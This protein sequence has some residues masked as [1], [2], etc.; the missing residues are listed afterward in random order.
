M[1]HNFH[2]PSAIRRATSLSLHYSH[3]PQVI[4][5]AYP[6]PEA[7][8]LFR[9]R[10]P[11]CLRAGDLS[12]LNH[13][14]TFSFPHDSA[15][16]DVEEISLTFLKVSWKQKVHACSTRSD[17]FCSFSAFLHTYSISLQSE[18]RSRLRRRLQPQTGRGGRGVSWPLGGLKILKVVTHFKL[19]SQITEW[20]RGEVTTGWLSNWQPQC[21][22]TAPLTSD[23]HV[24][25][26]T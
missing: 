3:K 4:F 6:G 10:C 5:W 12:R 24:H 26:S 23:I 16:L 2:F 22:L 21:L 15:Y 18:G 1:H 19:M 8:F 20:P 17:L 14:V 11:S 25:T 7:V 9:V 13:R